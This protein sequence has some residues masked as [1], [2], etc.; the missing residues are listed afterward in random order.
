MKKRILSWALIAVI[1]FT[2]AIGNF[3]LVKAGD[4]NAFNYT[5][6]SLSNEED[7]IINANGGNISGNIASNSSILLGSINNNGRL[8]ENVKNQKPILSDIVYEKYFNDGKGEMLDNC[9]DTQLNNSKRVINDINIT[10]D[11]INGN[12]IALI[13]EKGNILVD[14]NNISISGLIYAP[15]GKVILKGNNVNLN[16]ICIIADS[17]DIEAGN[18][19]INPSR[20]IMD[21]LTDNI[22]YND[23]E[24]YLYVMGKC[25]DNVI[26]IKWYTNCDNSNV[27]LYESDNN[28]EYNEITTINEASSYK[29]EIKENFDIKYIKVSNKY[30]ESVPFVVTKS[31]TGYSTDMLDSDSDGIPD[32]LEIIIGTNQYVS[33]TDE[34][35][36]NDYDEIMKTNSDPCVWDSLKEGLKDGLYD[37]DEDG[38]DN[39]TELIYGTDPLKQDTDED[40]LSDWEEIMEYHTNPLA[41]DT[42]NDNL[43]DRSEIT[44]GTDPCNEDS[45]SDGV[46][47]GDEIYEQDIKRENY[48]D[49]IFEDNVAIPNIKVKQKGDANEVINCEDYTGYLKG[50]DREY[51]GKCIEISGSNAESG[52]ISFDLTNDYIIPLYKYDDF[53]TNGLIICANINEETIPLKTTFDEETRKL[54]AEFIGDGIYFVIDTI[55]W[56]KGIGIEPEDIMNDI[57]KEFDYSGESA[58]CYNDEIVSEYNGE[59]QIAGKKV[60]GQVDIVFVV[61]TTGSMRASINNVKQNIQGFVDELV[62]ANIKPYFSLVEYKDITC[63]GEDSTNVK[64]NKEDNSCWFSSIDEFKKEI[65][66]LTVFGGGDNPET[67][68]DGLEFARRLNMRIYSQKFFILVT[69]D[70]YKN[71]NTYNIKNMDDMVELLLKDKINTSVITEQQYKSAY[72]NLYAT[73]GGIYAD[74]KGNFKNELLGIANKIIDITNDG[75]WIALNGLTPLIVKLDAKPVEGSSVDTDNDGLSDVEELGSTKPVRKYNAVDYISKLNHMSVSLKPEKLEKWDI[76]VY[77]YNSNPAKEDTDGDGLLDGKS[78]RDTL[79]NVCIPQDSQ[80]KIKNGDYRIWNYYKKVQEENWTQTEYSG[81]WGLDLG[82]NK[83]LADFIVDILLENKDNLS[84]IGYSTRKF[85]LAFKKFNEG[86]TELGAYLLNFIHDKNNVAYHSQP[87]TWQR[88]FGYNDFYDDVFDFGSYMDKGKYTFNYRGK[89]HVLWMWKGDYWNLQSGAEIGLYIYNREVTEHKQYDAI[90][91]EIPME[92][93]LFNIDDSMEKI[94][95]LFN[96]KPGVYQ[97]WVTGFNPEFKEANPMKMTS[98]GKLKLEDNKDLY[99]AMKENCENERNYIDIKRKNFVFD[100]ENYC[101]WVYFGNGEKL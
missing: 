16:G 2:N 14:A 100:D 7:L 84:S 48:Q 25:D 4:E 24:K 35:G 85:I 60:S 29:Y 8:Y 96:W 10:S 31:S 30:M 47:D 21:L 92:L 86:N 69:D 55:N 99:Y 95:C 22:T 28:I 64:I 61:D 3:K 90:D 13:S 73:T 50:D 79:G 9:V 89:E 19:N 15:N 66:N 91:Y 54:S 74:I 80:P 70:D 36:V 18:A 88:Q 51:V 37:I 49:S 23:K 82:V 94:E 81:D 62:G 41:V 26:N 42:D 20:E 53:D 59:L 5:F 72:E 17:I 58:V 12:N 68:I 1:A 46:L 39:Q 32:M 57:E 27:V 98:I 83:H 56:L 63:D 34:D 45:N 76:Y 67:A 65:G 40:G 38:L 44:L 52:E 11:C 33:D 97:W 6:L 75:E 87:D 77:N 78:Q 101:I 93:A 43:Q 71:D